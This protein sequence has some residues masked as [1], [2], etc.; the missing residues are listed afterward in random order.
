MVRHAQREWVTRKMWKA[1]TKTS[2]GVSGFM[3]GEGR[4]RFDTTRRGFNRCCC[5]RLTLR[6]CISGV[7]VQI[8]Y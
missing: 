4:G 2:V 7:L 3:G 5:S 1:S 8:I 6:C